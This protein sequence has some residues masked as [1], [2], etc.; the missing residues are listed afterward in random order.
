[1]VLTQQMLERHIEDTILVYRCK[2]V[3]FIMEELQDIFGDVIDEDFTRHLIACKLH[4]CF[5]LQPVSFDV[6]AEMMN[7]LKDCIKQAIKTTREL[8]KSG[9][10]KTIK[11]RR[12]A[13]VTN[14]R[15]GLGQTLWK[16]LDKSI[17]QPYYT[18]IFDPNFWHDIGITKGMSNKEHV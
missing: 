2:D 12:G 16:D 5:G 13:F 6:K 8:E 11:E 18:K 4:A 7:L 17:T 3:D 1:M 15:R 10:L 9:V 14:L